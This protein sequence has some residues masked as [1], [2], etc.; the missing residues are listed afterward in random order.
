MVDMR[1]AL[2]GAGI[3]ADGRIFG[4]LASLNTRDNDVAERALAQPG[5][6]NHE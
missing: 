1:L 6:P 2:T 5:Q 4:D 3:A